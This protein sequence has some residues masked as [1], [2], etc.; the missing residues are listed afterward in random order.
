L[1][2]T[3]STILISWNQLQKKCLIRHAGCSI[4]GRKT[5]ND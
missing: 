5:E 3:I 1:M 2:Q 4:S